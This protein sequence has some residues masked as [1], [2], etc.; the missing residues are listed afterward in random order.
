MKKLI[1]ILLLIGIIFIS[2][3]VNVRLKAC[4]KEAKQCPGGGGV[5]RNASNNCEFDPCPIVDNYINCEINKD[6]QKAFCIQ[7]YDPVCGED[8]N[9]YSNSCVAC[10]SITKYKKGEC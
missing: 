10:Q 2:G 3:C 8:G 1:L 5:V 9:T 7:I 6:T 4:T